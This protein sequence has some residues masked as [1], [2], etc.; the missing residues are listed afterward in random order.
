MPR[1]CGRGKKSPI[2]IRWRGDAL[3][4]KDPFYT[5]VSG[6]R[7]RELSAPGQVARQIELIATSRG[8]PVGE[9][10]AREPELLQQFGVSRETLREAIRI[11]ESR[12]AMRM[13]RGRAGGLSVERPR[14]ERVAGA[15]ATFLG[16][17]GISSGEFERAVQAMD[18]LLVWKLA[19][20]E[21]PLPQPRG[22]ETARQ[23]LARANG[24]SLL[25]VFVLALERLA[26]SGSGTKE[27][28]G[29]PAQLKAAVS[30]GDTRTALALLQAAPVVFAEE[31]ERRS[32]A[33]RAESLALRMMER[34]EGEGDTVLGSEADLLSEYD[35]S[36]AT[37]RQA[38]RILQDL[39]V[40]HVRRGRGGGY[41]LKRP[42]PIGIIRQMFPLLAS[43]QRTPGELIEMMWDLNAVNLRQAARRLLA[44]D[45]AANLPAQCDRLERLLDEHTEPERFIL[46]QQ[47]FAAIA[48]NP[49][50]DTLAR[51]VVSYQARIGGAPGMAPPQ[52]HS[53]IRERAL[54]AALRSRDAAEAER[55][56]RLLQE[57]MTAAIA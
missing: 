56:L 53:L 36:R 46:L 32:V 6:E 30:Q 50:V 5:F 21:D 24:E 44:P 51:C 7:T 22:R 2:W 41:T 11:V 15:F 3:S 45:E 20:I 12:G 37:I 34:A 4:D 55:L 25:G 35:T 38:I 27:P 17:N 48:S 29:L 40:L 39:D 16:A 14:I 10:I 13:R 9:V 47:S 19:R 43:E 26:P 1:T 52:D 31:D 33:L 42:S 28:P 18:L 8:W 57:E 49:A 23:W 54:I